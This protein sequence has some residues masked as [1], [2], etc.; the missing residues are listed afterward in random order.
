MAY[1]SPSAHADAAMPLQAMLRSSSS[2]HSPMFVSLC[3]RLWRA[4]FQAGSPLRTH[5]A[6]L[7]PL[8]WPRAVTLSAT[9]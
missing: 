5:V 4:H 7:R 9:L 1:T 3:R 2:L 6:R 8:L